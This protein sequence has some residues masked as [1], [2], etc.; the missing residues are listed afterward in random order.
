M[1]SVT[2]ISHKTYDSQHP[3][4]MVTNREGNRYFFGKV[5]EGSQ[6]VL[7]ENR[8]RLGKLK[9]I[10][11]TG[12]L[13]SWSQIGGLP[14]LFLTIS[15]STKKNIDV[16][17]NSGKIL[18]YI[19][20]TWRYFVFRKGVEIKII[21]ADENKFIADSNLIIRPIKIAPNQSSGSITSSDADDTIY[22]KLKNLVSLMFPLDTS[23][24]ND[25][26]PNSYKSDPADND[27][28]THVSIEDVEL[29]P[30]TQSSLN[31]LIRF[32]PIRGKF[33]PVRAKQLGIKPGV[34]FRHLT[35]GQAVAN[36]KGEMIQPNQ[37]MGESKHF[38]KVLILDI[39]SNLFL[40]N[41]ME[42]TSFF[43]TKDEGSGH[44]HIGIVYHLLGDEINFELNEYL[45]F[46]KRFPSDCQHVISHSKISSNTII[47]RTFSID[48]LKLKSIANDNFNLPYNEEYSPLLTNIAGEL[49]DKKTVN[50]L[51]QL[52]QFV[53]NS[54][55]VELD[56]SLV[57]DNTWSSIYDK[58][59][60][61]LKQTTK[62]VASKSETT[63]NKPLSL[64]LLNDYKLLK[65]NVQ[66]TTLGTGS[67]L[68]S[69]YRNVLSNL[70][71]IPIKQAGTGE[72]KFTSIL[73]DAGENTLGTLL[74][75]FGHG[76]QYET[77]FKELK[78]IYLSHLHADHHLGIIS[79]VNK[80]FEVNKDSDDL[81]HLVIP[82]QYDHF[83]T[84][85]YKL[86]GHNSSIDMSRINY[87]SCEEFLKI[88]APEYKRF[89][90]DHFLENITSNGPKLE[91]VRDNLKPL[92][93][94]KISKLYKDLS[95]SELNTCRAIHCYWSYSVSINFNLSDDETF[96][97]SYSGDTR[98]ST[99]FV[100]IGYNSD[101]LLHESTLD[102]ELIEEA[103][104][105]KHSTMIEAINVAKYMNC[106]KLILTHFSTRY[107]NRGDFI[108]DKAEFDKLSYDMKN[109]LKEY[110]GNLNSQSNIFSLDLAPNSKPRIEDFNDLEILYAFDT[111]ITRLSKIHEQKQYIH[112]V[113]QI[114][115]DAVNV[116]E[117]AG[118]EN[119]T[120][121]KALKELEKQRIK[122]EAKRIQRLSIQ[123]RRK[124][125]SDEEAS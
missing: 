24:V 8:F 94:A 55:S 79:V 85:W 44:E 29:N 38:Q 58:Y 6:R 120:E 112:L 65:D 33:D 32:Q 83:M 125:S 104:S 45:E 3:L 117:M 109:Y 77:I 97:V 30:E 123:K 67:A 62:E 73:L 74:R 105:K 107:S 4:L 116:D 40:K 80:W 61:P 102:N 47:F 72:I 23:K 18:S 69:I 53:I 66:I 96:K 118:E 114:M 71:R 20:A 91:L 1:F 19:V 124:V 63:N 13:N 100:D 111:L 56:E 70:I 37:V 93:H 92:S 57:S 16:Y 17:T 9:G 99:R 101:L 2:T 31:Y 48:L 108:L 52:Q 60:A 87:I 49:K 110:D 86:E 106:K 28:Q 84:E 14:G 98:P 90:L 115:D 119:T 12:T 21:D 75:T 46:I 34:D 121:V 39:P 22:K 81:L 103:I 36:D 25:P 59:V 89:S 88:R 7:N 15:D 68:P 27:V 5:G 26:D 54:D 51:H 50:K 122:R 35:Q 113:N 11:L 10:F 78:L 76:K 64:G 82:W 41:T 43:D 95:I 42:C